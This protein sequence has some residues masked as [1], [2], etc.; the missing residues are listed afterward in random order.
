MNYRKNSSGKETIVTKFLRERMVYESLFNREVKFVD[1]YFLQMLGVDFFVPDRYIFVD[2][3]AA[4][5]YVNAEFRNLVGDYV[6]TA[7][8]H[9]GWMA[10]KE[11]LTTHIMQEFIITNDSR[12]NDFRLEDI[13]AVDI[14]VI[15]FFKLK[16]YLDKIG[17]GIDAACLILRYMNQHNMSL[18]HNKRDKNVELRIS[19]GYR[20][21]PAFVR[22]KYDTL[23]NKI[24]ARC[25]YVRCD[26]KISEGF[27]RRR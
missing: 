21:A 17:W 7:T 4:V 23:V 2:E 3:K 6:N 25:F 20:E 24:G 11:S 14:M 9:R 12:N 10:D 5:N 16:R 22:V 8:N 27:Y 13:L 1:T 19:K 18:M 26:G 15:D